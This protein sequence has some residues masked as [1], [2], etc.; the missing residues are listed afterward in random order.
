[1][2]KMTNFVSVKGLNIRRE[3]DTI[4]ISHHTV[5]SPWHASYVFF[6]LV[7]GQLLAVNCY[8][9]AGQLTCH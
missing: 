6:V 8:L 7:S 5:K 9:T 4:F 1:M 3:G 2:G